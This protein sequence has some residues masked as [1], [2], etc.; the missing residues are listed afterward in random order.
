MIGSSR[1]VIPDE[2]ICTVGSSLPTD[3]RAGRQ[4]FV[5]YQG[6]SLKKRRQKTIFEYLSIGSLLLELGASSLALRTYI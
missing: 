2:N 5:I 6:F 1:L 3:C 4:R